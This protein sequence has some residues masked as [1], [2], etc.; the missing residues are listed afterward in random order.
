M[1]KIL[2]VD[3]EPLNNKLILAYLSDHPYEVVCAT[4]A[5]E[6][7]T[8]LQAEHFDLIL[9]DRMMPDMDGLEF[10]DKL[11]HNPTLSSIPIILQTAAAEKIKLAEGFEAGIVDIITK[12]FDE[13]DLITA[14]NVCLH[15]VYK[16]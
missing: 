16:Q 2:V 6:A 5:E 14:I 8:K 15:R 9:L 1:L 13:C 11:K 10:A 3:D 7:Y 4:S 12:P